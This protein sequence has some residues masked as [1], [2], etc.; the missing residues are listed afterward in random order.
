M[1][2]NNILKNQY[3]YLKQIIIMDWWEYLDQKYI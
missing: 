3:K 2:A 1:I